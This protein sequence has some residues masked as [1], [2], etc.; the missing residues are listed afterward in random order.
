[1]SD[2]SQ[3]DGQSQA[4]VPTNAPV[5]S[6][7]NLQD[8]EDQPPQDSP[9]QML[10][11][12]QSLSE[13][14]PQQQSFSPSVM[15]ATLSE[16]QP[17][18]QQEP[19]YP[20]IV[21]TSVVERPQERP[22]ERSQQPVH[23]ERQ[24]KKPQEQQD[25]FSPDA[26]LA[27]VATA[28]I[29][30]LIPPAAP[31]APPPPPPKGEKARPRRTK[32]PSADKPLEKQRAGDSLSPQVESHR[33]SAPNHGANGANAAN[34]E[35]IQI[36]DSDDAR[37]PAETRKPP[38]RRRSSEIRRQSETRRPLETRRPTENGRRYPSGLDW[39]IPMDETRASEE[40]YDVCCTPYLLTFSP[41]L[42]R[43][44]PSENGRAA[45]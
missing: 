23:R 8:D 39:I 17:E 45:S 30:R 2:H 14:Q 40:P 6:T 13:D 33:H 20:A 19:F 42:C 36:R 7:D 18:E 44:G 32:P 4:S 22:Q 29:D 35:R 27:R 43:I 34:A 37:R 31:Q 1:M 16:D 11:P 10:E 12:E 28:A 15:L 38:E 26:L 5:G 3:S 41:K 24:Q 21:L 9:E 25:L